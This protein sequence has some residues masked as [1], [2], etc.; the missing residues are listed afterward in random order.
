LENAARKA[1][2]QEISHRLAALERTRQL[3]VGGML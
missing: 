1:L 3:A 2:Q